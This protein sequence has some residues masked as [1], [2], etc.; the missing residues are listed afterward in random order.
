[1]PALV[2]VCVWGGGGLSAHRVVSVE[3]G[4][5]R[6]REEQVLFI[7]TSAKAG[8]NVKQLFRKLATA[9]P[10]MESAAPARPD[11]CACARHCTRLARAALTARACACVTCA[12][13]DI[14]LTPHA[15]GGAAAGAPAAGGCQC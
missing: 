4:E 8:Y 13:I 12:V 9:L 10:G 1:M 3:E 2:G 7:E 14:K 5:E 6:S 15:D 11:N